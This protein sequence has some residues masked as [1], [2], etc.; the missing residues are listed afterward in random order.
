MN[1][2]GSIDQHE[3]IIGLAGKDRIT[4]LQNLGA[5][6]APIVGVPPR[7][8]WRALLRRERMSSTAIG[9]G[10]AVPHALLCEI[11][12]PHK[13]LAV[14]ND[15]VWYDSPD[16]APVSI[17]LGILWPKAHEDEYL[18]A[19]ARLVRRLRAPDVRGGLLSAGSP[20]QA[21]ESLSRAGDETV[22]S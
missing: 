4:V 19:L 17:M 13:C 10:V 1:A 3:I 5:H 7:S 15:A 16:G 9:S 6:F 14:L 12:R 2:D 18:P 20:E 21:A 8:I 22:W 11:D